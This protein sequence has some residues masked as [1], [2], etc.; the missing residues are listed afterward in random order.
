LRSLFATITSSIVDLYLH[1]QERQT[2]EWKLR[3][4]MVQPK[5]I[6]DKLI[7][8]CVYIAACFFFFI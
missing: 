3:Y 2:Q 1:K 5:N 4:W 7:F 8:L 6:K